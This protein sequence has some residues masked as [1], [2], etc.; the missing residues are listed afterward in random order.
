MWNVLATPETDG[1]RIG[2]AN[3]GLG[4]TGRSAN[5]SYVF[6]F[7]PIGKA[8]TKFELL[9]AGPSTRVE[10]DWVDDGAEIIDDLPTALAT[11]S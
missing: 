7:L 1:S 3:S 5:T 11:I 8:T 2:E 9:D 10:T 6:N 4:A